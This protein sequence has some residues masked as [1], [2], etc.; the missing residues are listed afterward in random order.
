LGY[1]YAGLMAASDADIKY[2]MDIIL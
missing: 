1:W 2:A